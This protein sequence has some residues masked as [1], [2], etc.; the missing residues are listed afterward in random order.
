M[1]PHPLRDPIWHNIAKKLNK[2]LLLLNEYL[3]LKI[4]KE[5]DNATDSEDRT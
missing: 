3:A 5:K 2:T 4:Q 1:N